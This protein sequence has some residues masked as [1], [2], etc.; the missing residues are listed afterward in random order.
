MNKPQQK[1][2]KIMENQDDVTLTK[3]TASQLWRSKIWKW[4][5]PEKLQNPEKEIK[6]K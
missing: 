6:I 5:R 3:I 4:I 2:R 1:N